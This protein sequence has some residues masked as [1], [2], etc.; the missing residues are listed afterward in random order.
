MEVAIAR[1]D[2]LRA[3]QTYEERLVRL[4]QQLG[5]V[6]VRDF[7]VDPEVLIQSAEQ[8]TLPDS[9]TLE[10]AIA[11]RGAYLELLA[12]TEVVAMQLNQAR[13]R[14]RSDLSLRADT[15]WQGEDPTNPFGHDRYVS[16]RHVGAVV[17]LTWRRPLGFR[18][19]KARVDIHLARLAELREQLRETRLGIEADLEVA[20]RDFGLAREQLAL[21]TQAVKQAEK[22]LSAEDERFRLGE[23]RSRNVLDAQKDLTNV[24]QRQT[25]V[26]A[27]LLRA[28]S[29]FVH[30]A[31]YAGEPGPES[32]G[33][34]AQQ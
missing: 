5:D 16:D 23:G 14:I 31:G 12:D 1:A 9:Y 4:A 10:A 15:V 20:E 25:R 32:E 7:A 18:T 34:P 27:T 8:S 26:A 11:P 28:R 3:Q 17:T 2:E 29:A 33:L 21:V 30:A 24:I 13:D 19:E 6:S 22:T